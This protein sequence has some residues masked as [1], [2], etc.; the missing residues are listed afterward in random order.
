MD[1]ANQDT[2]TQSYI[3]SLEALI[4]SF[5]YH[6]QDYGQCRQQM[7]A[8]MYAAILVNPIID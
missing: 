5:N 2:D 1:A 3:R 4:H 7:Q 8:Y 6:L